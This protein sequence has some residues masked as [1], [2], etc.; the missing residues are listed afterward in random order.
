VIDPLLIERFD[1]TEVGN[2]LARKTYQF[3]LPAPSPQAGCSVMPGKCLRN[4][5]LVLFFFLPSSPS[6]FP[7]KEQVSWRVSQSLLYIP[8]QQAL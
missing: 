8:A 4:S 7:G 6:P 1:S 3:E 2:L 5:I